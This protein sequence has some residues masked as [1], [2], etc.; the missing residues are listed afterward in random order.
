M[1]DPMARPRAQSPRVLVIGAT[2][3]VGRE[4]VAELKRRPGRLEVVA[5]SRSAPDQS[6]QLDLARPDTVERLIGSVRPDHVI[7]AA[8]ATNVVWCEEHPERSAAI[9]VIGAEAV[10][11]AARA[12]RATLTF[13]ST[14]YV[15]DGTRGPY[16][17][18]AD[19][20]PINVYGAHKLA[21]EA[22]IL[23]VDP[24]NLIIRTCQVF[25]AD[26]RRMNF[27]IRV[28]DQLRRGEPVEAAGDLF[29]TPTY[30]QDLARALVELTLSRASGI[31]HVAGNSFLSRYELARLVAVAFGFEHAAIVEVS[32]DQMEDSV[33]RPRRA[34][35]R[36]A[37]LARAGIGV[38][39]PINESLSTLAAEEKSR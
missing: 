4:L 9:N 36:T 28:T 10:A 33:N 27:V 3:Q 12:T 29:G 25:G 23:A 14:D 7:L 17:E 24:N 1:N 19:T 22:A 8:A 37:R 18:D 20:N 38:I 35:L 13:I 11:K 5:A 30:A 15:F 2:G 31:W 34:G 26:P 32:A 39:T 16:A 21:A 6:R